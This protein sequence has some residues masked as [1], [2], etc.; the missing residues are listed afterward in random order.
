MCEIYGQ[1]QGKMVAKL[2]LLSWTLAMLTL[3]VLELSLRAGSPLFHIIH[4]LESAVSDWVVYFFLF[5]FFVPFF[6]AGKLCVFCKICHLNQD[7]L[8]S[9]IE[10][11]QCCLLLKQITLEE[12]LCPD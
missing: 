4:Q 9:L 12:S 8:V 7:N 6:S 2:W 3:P 10:G 11:P 1:V 5:F